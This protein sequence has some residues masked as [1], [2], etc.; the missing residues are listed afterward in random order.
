VPG[1]LGWTHLI[2]IIRIDDEHERNFYLVETVNE[3]WSSRQ[4]IQ[5]KERGLFMQLALGK[6]KEQILSLAM[7]GNIVEKPEDAIKDTYTLDFLNIPESKPSESTLE[8]ALI[9][10]P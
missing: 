4:L 1:K 5:Q 2:E 6:S 9:E 8:D 10:K 3:N 7:H